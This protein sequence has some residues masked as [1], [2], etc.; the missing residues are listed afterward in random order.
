MTVLAAAETATDAGTDTASFVVCYS[1]C[2][3]VSSYGFCF[4]EIGRGQEVFCVRGGLTTA[5]VAA[6][7][8][9]NS[10]KTDDGDSS[11]TREEGH[12]APHCP[13]ID[14]RN[15]PP[16]PPPTLR[17]E[18][19]HTSRILTHRRR[20]VRYCHAGET[21]GETGWRRRRRPPPP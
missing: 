10:L 5:G 11:E 6:D 7:T 9:I 3:N 8:R 16:P 17:G 18:V 2:G 12:G 15:V 19:A 13:A 21:G 20:G 14:W 1:H 4:S